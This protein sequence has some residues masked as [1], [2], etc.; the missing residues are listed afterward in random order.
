[1]HKCDS[2]LEPEDS[3]PCKIKKKKK[4]RKSNTGRDRLA[5]FNH[6]PYNKADFTFD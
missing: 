4:K 2:G 6:K 5:D 3:A 1:M